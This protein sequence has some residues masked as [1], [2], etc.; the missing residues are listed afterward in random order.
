MAAPLGLELS[1]EPL[2]HYSSRQDVLIWA[3][4]EAVQPSGSEPS[5]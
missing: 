1:S 3:L 4:E 2:L 5:R